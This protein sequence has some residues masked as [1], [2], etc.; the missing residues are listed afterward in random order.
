MLAL[1]RGSTDG[2]VRRLPP[3][4]TRLVSL[5]LHQVWWRHLLEWWGTFA[6]TFCKIIFNFTFV[7]YT[8][9]LPIGVDRNYRM[10][11]FLHNPASFTIIHL[12]MYARL[13][14]VL[15]FWPFWITTSMRSVFVWSYF[16]VIKI[17]IKWIYSFFLQRITLLRVALFVVFGHKYL[18]FVTN[19]MKHNKKA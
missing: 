8:G 18:M 3:L 14:W 6:Y 12:V 15:R 11:R 7:L 9:L 1:Q 13:L 2:G 5:E 19:E 17:F 10:L 4:A 16:I